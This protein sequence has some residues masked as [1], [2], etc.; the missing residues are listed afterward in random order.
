MISITYRNSLW[1]IICSIKSKVRRERFMK[2]NILWVI[3]SF[4]L[5]VSFLIPFFLSPS[6]DSEKSLSQ[7]SSQRSRSIHLPKALIKNPGKKEVSVLLND[8]AM[9][10]KWGLSQMETQKAWAISQGSKKIKI[11][12]IDT[13]VD[14]HHEDLKDNIWTNP[15]ETGLDSKGKNKATNGIDDDGNGFVDDI[16]GWNFV[17]NNTNLTDN[18]GHGTHISGIIGALGG[19][20]KGVSGISPLVSLMVLKYYDPSAQGKNNLKNTIKSIHYAIDNGAHIINY[21]GGGLEFS[22]EEKKAIEK[23]RTRGILVVAAAGNEYSNSDIK[24]YYPA[25]YNLDNIISVTAVNH[26]TEVLP[27]SNFGISTVDIGAPGKNIYSTFTKNRYGT[28]TGTSQA[29]AFVSG[30][31][32]LILA[33]HTDYRPYQIAKYLKNTGDIVEPLK[34]K[35]RFK[36]RLN[37]YRALS[38]ID[39]DMGATGVIA[40]NT[41]QMKREFT[42][43]KVFPQKRA[44]QGSLEE[45]KK[46]SKD[47]IKIIGTNK[48]S[49]KLP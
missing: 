44:A 10:Q 28:M 43:K 20:G 38:I 15:G 9:N 2:S 7:L 8:P 5:S 46:F 42:T 34:G 47:L 40:T 13:G 19:N 48:S 31:A 16:H 11:A 17:N 26:K 18:H 14:V 12:V 3:G 1:P 23:A 33:H 32:A 30:V 4:F 24:K 6:N 35:T 41:S 45:I 36:R 39:S 37:S 49:S 25:D 27:S 22:L 21:S 29:T